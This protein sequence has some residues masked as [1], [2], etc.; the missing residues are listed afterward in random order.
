MIISKSEKFTVG[1]ILEV[2]KDVYESIK[3]LFVTN[4]E[5]VSAYGARVTK[6]NNTPILYLGTAKLISRKDIINYEATQ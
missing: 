3:H 6:I 1:S 5:S 4:W 2:F